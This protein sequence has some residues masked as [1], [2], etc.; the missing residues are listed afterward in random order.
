MRPENKRMTEFLNQNGIEAKVKYIF[1]GSLKH[2]WRIYNPDIKWTVAI[3]EK[4]ESLGFR[5][6]SGGKFHRYEINGKI[7][8]CE[9]NGGILSIFARGHEE[10][11]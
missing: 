1:T 7:I 5:S 9:G 4:L 2:T 6:Y 10:L 3:A 11:L 8:S